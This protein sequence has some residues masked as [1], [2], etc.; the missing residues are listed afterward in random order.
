MELSGGDRIGAGEDES[1][2]SGYEGRG[3]YK[4]SDFVG[5][6]HRSRD[7]DFVGGVVWHFLDVAGGRNDNG[8]VI[9]KL[10]LQDL[11]GGLE[12]SVLGRSTSPEVNDPLFGLNEFVSDNRTS[13]SVANST[14]QLI[15]TDENTIGLDVPGATTVDNDSAISGNLVYIVGVQEDIEIL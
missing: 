5:D 14:F 2:V 7:V 11:T 6:V 12:N 3:L 4:T 13:E 10:I 15:R 1:D 9:T 8:N